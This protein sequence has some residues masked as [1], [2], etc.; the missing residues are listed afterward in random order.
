MGGA[1]GVG[2]ERMEGVEAG[3]HEFALGDGESGLETACLQLGKERVVVRWEGE[4]V[5]DDRLS[6]GAR[7]VAWRRR[8]R[9]SERVEFAGEFVQ[10]IGI[11]GHVVPG[12]HHV[13]GVPILEGVAER[14]VGGD[15]P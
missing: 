10:V 5:A 9:L 11:E 7:R 12:I 6:R 14:V 3:A 2:G 8:M 15:G 1:E 13:G 4:V